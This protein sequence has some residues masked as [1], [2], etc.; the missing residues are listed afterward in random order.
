MMSKTG[1]KKVLCWLSDYYFE[2]YGYTL[3]GSYGM[4]ISTDGSYLVI[5]MNGAFKGPDG[6]G[7]GHPSL[8]IIEIPEEERVE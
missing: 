7:Y 2:H 4:E 1:T 6:G 5:V 3:G 8:F